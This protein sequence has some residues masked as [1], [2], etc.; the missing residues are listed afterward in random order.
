MVIIDLGINF[1]NF[2]CCGR[3]N[4]QEE[5]IDFG[6]RKVTIITIIRLFLMPLVGVPLFFL[7]NYLQLLEDDHLLLFFFLFMVSAPHAITIIS[8]CDIKETK[9]KINTNIIFLIFY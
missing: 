9:V 8:V 1:A 7:Y 6:C 5:S 4:E 3:P 2:D